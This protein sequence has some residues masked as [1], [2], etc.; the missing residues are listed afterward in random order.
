MKTT[1]NNEVKKNIA[2]IV[3]MI[4]CFILGFVFAPSQEV[5]EQTTLKT[6]DINQLDQSFEPIKVGMEVY[7]TIQP[8]EI[9]FTYKDLRNGTYLFDLNNEFC[10]LTKCTGKIERGLCYVCKD[11]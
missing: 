2:I 9:V 11:Y 3:I 1:K 6:K 4:F 7:T 10:K 8:S 5:V